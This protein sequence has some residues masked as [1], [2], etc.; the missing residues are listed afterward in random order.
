MHS[1]WSNATEC[2]AGYDGKM[3]CRWY[4]LV[5]I[6]LISCAS[7]AACKSEEDRSVRVSQCPKPLPVSEQIPTA[8]LPQAVSVTADQRTTPVPAVFLAPLLLDDR[9]EIAALLK[10]LPPGVYRE[11]YVRGVGKFYLD[12]VVDVIKGILKRGQPWE[13]HIDELL[14]KHIKPGTTVID[15]GAHIGT[16][17]LAMSRFVGPDGLVYSF[18]PQKKLYR[19]LVY[20]LRLNKVANVVAV[21]LALGL[22]PSIIEMSPALHANEGGTGIGSGGDRAELRALDQIPFT[23]VSV[24]KIDV[25]GFEDNVLEGARLTIA[26]WRPV[27]VIE[28]MGGNTYNSAPPEIR[29]RI[30]ATRKKLET[31]GYKVEHVSEHDYLALPV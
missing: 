9:E 15:A 18:E 7:F 3:I 8:E 20:N 2:E 6:T 11:Y 5:Y 21:R 23:N 4:Q 14:R 30:D 22:S 19:E 13:P 28:I 12:D 29:A 17:A 16:H 1:S 27:I 10:A 26:R 25:E 31:M 24:M